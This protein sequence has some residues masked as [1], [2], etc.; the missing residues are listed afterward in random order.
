MLGDIMTASQ[1]V[2]R[3][4]RGR[5]RPVLRGH[6]WIFSGAVEEIRGEPTVGAVVDVLSDGG[7]WLARGLVHPEAAL[8]VRIYTWKQDEAI[9]AGFFARRID[10]A[11]AFREQ[12]FGDSDP[13]TN[14][15]RLVFSESDGISGII[16]DRYAD[17]LA[18]QLS[19]KVLQPYLEGILDHLAKRTGIDKVHVVA[20]ED[21]VEREKL[22]PAGLPSSLS[23]GGQIVRIRESGFSFDVDLGS[24]QKTGFFLDQRLNRRR[25]AAYA[26]GR[27]VLSAYCYT[28]AFEIHAAAGGATKIVG[29]DRSE[30]AL[31][32]AREHHQLNGT[33]VPAEYTR[34]EVP[35]ALR[36]FRDA[37][38]T[39]DMIILD[40]P[41][42]VAN[43]A[44]L[45]KGLRAYK[46]I[47]LLAMKLLSPG[48]ILVSF[49]CSGQV[50]SEDFKTMIGWASVDAGRTALITETL[51]Q[52][53]DHPVLA[54]FPESEYLKGVVCVLS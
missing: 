22:E 19:A 40:P 47:N 45:E 35:D 20:D 31:V 17:V 25:V 5:D 1:A 28:G 50:S 41:R 44:Q 51:T 34:A 4:K 8:T 18:V 9:D 49:S 10:A 48:G 16:V 24:G 26:K 14:A 36:R 52:P 21:S 6:P 42:F 7:T 23:P 53:P 54:V 30:S 13:G 46:D 37:G 2:V 11:V 32:R 3:L 12:L 38:E 29:I 27:R 15:Y 39:F 33:T 43:R